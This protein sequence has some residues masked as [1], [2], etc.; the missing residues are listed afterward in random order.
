MSWPDLRLP[1]RHQGQQILVAVGGDQIEG[2]VDLFLVGPFAAELAQDLAGAR[3][4]VVP[5][6]DGKLAGGVGAAHKGC[7]ERGRG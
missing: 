6:A 1:L 4:P 7:G 3:D 5:G 2:E